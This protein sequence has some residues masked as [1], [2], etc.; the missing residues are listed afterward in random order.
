MREIACVAIPRFGLV[1]SCGQERVAGEPVVLL[2]GAG[3]NATVLEASWRAEARGIAAGMS[4]AQA[5][6][7]CPEARLA[8]PDPLAAE[9]L[10]AQ[11]PAR[12]EG[13][14][15]A[16][17]P[18]RP[19][20]AFFGPAGLLGLHCT[21]V[22]GL[23]GTVRRAVP[24][25]V[26]SAAAPAR[27]ASAVLDRRLAPELGTA[28]ERIVE[29]SALRAFLAPLPISALAVGPGLPGREAEELVATLERLGVWTLGGLAGIG[30]EQIADRFGRLG[31]AA[32]RIARGED[33]DLDPRELRE[34]VAESLDLPDGAAAGAQLEHGLEMLVERLLRRP[35]RE[36]RTS[37]PSASRPASREAAAG[38]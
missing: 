23:L 30:A 38:R 12:L 31:L 22:G 18:G 1:A 4:R 27:F 26:R 6:A 33:R 24:L 17:E 19:G 37:S 25:R 9:E 36:A 3:A 10:W 35:E 14:G 8:V 20:E 34:E 32:R 2:R 5:L 21:D 28:G 13:L 29:A 11:V 16:V 7:R 15:A